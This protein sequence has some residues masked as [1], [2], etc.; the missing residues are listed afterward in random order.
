MQVA[1]LEAVLKVN[2]SQALLSL[3]QQGLLAREKIGRVYVYLSPQAKQVIDPEEIA[4]CQILHERDPMLPSKPPPDLTVRE[5]QIAV[6]KL[7]GFRPTKRQSV[8]GT[9]L[10]W[11][12]TKILMVAMQTVRAFKTKELIADSWQYGL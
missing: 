5:H 12:G 10:T 7:A 1:E 6:G 3:H 2:P 4:T 8:P 9:K 11:I